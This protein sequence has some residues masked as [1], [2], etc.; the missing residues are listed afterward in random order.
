M[1][2]SVLSTDQ[3]AKLCHVAPR[4]VCKW[5]DEELL[6][7]YRIPGSKFRRVQMADLAAFIKEYNLPCLKLGCVTT[8][9]LSE[10]LQKEIEDAIK[11]ASIAVDVVH[12]NADF[13]GGYITRTATSEVG[14]RTVLVVDLASGVRNALE[15]AFTIDKLKVLCKCLYI[16][17]EDLVLADQQEFEK[18]G[19]KLLSSVNLISDILQ[20]VSDEMQRSISLRRTYTTQKKK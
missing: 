12:A 10:A 11:V 2:N 16:P 6:K 20:H 1:N 15:L 17:V 5:I 9:G 4:T 19:W 7:G 3:V 13:M 8:I 14:Q 18:K